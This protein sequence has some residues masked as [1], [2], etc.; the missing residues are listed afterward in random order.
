MNVYIHVFAV[1]QL[2]IRYRAL[3]AGARSRVRGA[4]L[5]VCVSKFALADVD[6]ARKRS[7]IAG[8]PVVGDLQVM[9]PA[10]DED[11]AA[12]LGT[13][14]DAQAVD[15]RRV[16]GVVARERIAKIGRAHV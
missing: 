13:L 9:P 8:N 10:V 16:A 7:S 11:A 1:R 12:T 4:P 2:S 6:A 14:G 5:D 3:L 15:A